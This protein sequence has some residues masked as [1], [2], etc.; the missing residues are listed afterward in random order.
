MSTR[1]SPLPLLCYADSETSADMLYLAGFSV[2]DPFPALVM[3]DGETVGFFHPLEISRAQKESRFDRLVSTEALKKEIGAGKRGVPER[4]GIDLLLACWLRKEGWKKVEVPADFPVGMAERLR[5]R[6]IAVGVRGGLAFPEREGKSEWECRQIRRGNQASARGF[7][8]VRDILREAEIGGNGVLRWKGRVLTAERVREE[9]EKACMEKGALAGRVIAAC[10]EQAC[11]P[12]CE[13]HGPWRAH[14]LII[15][16]IFPRLR[17]T[18]Y[19]GDMTRTFLKGRAREGQKRLVATVRKAQKKALET[20]REGVSGDKVHGDIVADFEAAGYETSLGS[21]PPR[22]F[23]HGTGHGLGL[24]VHEAP[25]VSPGAPALRAGQ[26]ITVEP[27]L[28]YP[29]LGGCRIE[30]VV[31]VQKQGAEI[32]SRFPYRWQY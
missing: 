4:P 24:S 30:D 27:G 10:G 29:G 5:R 13:G 18:G 21:S 31:V 20:I 8:R 15:V 17:D 22:G 19:H 26:V 1:S 6:R 11:D 9:I 14:E 7:A 25:R 3:P 32:L 16:D 2:P 23:F 12:H 28:Y